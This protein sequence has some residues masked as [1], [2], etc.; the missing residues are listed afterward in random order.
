MWIE[1]IRSSCWWFLEITG[2]QSLDILGSEIMVPEDRSHHCTCN[3][4]ICIWVSSLLENESHKTLIYVRFRIL[5]DQLLK[6][7]EELECVGPGNLGLTHIG[8]CREIILTQYVNEVFIQERF[9]E[10]LIFYLVLDVP[11][12]CLEYFFWITR[13][14]S[15]S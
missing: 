7:I 14:N 2:K 15:L 12:N 1:L 4:T 5:P 6:I 11:L 8:S 10:L 9:L 3:G 13:Q